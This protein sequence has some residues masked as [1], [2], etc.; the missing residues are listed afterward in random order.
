MNQNRPRARTEAATTTE[1]RMAREFLALL[2]LFLAL[3]LSVS[4]VTFHPQDPS[5]NQA[6]QSE[7]IRNAAGL[8][9]AYLG[10]LLVEFAGL[11]AYLAIL[12][13]IWAGFQILVPRYALSWRRWTGYALTALCLSWWASNPWAQTLALGQVHGGGFTG[14]IL[15]L[16]SRTY[17]RPAGSWILWLFLSL[18]S[19]QLLFGLL[20]TRDGVVF[21]RGFPGACSG[22]MERIR[23]MGRRIA[24]LLPRG[25]EEEPLEWPEPREERQRRPVQPVRKKSRPKSPESESEPE[26]LPP[27]RH[28]PG[29]GFRI[30]PLDIRQTPPPAAAQGLQGTPRPAGRTLGGMPGRFRSSGPGAADNA[31]PRGHHVRIQARSGSEDQPDR[32][33]FR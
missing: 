23:E 7:D 4:V 31:R 33:S 26:I 21:A 14:S 3:F 12:A 6:S 29:L 27:P 1:H 19:L 22:L 11:S 28:A 15:H 16:L 8:V 32:Q 30:P 9:G 18:V 20:I 10:G 13:L 2:L 24:A 17:L 25:R 5:F